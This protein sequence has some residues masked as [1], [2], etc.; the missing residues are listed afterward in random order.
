MSHHVQRKVLFPLCSSDDCSL[1]ALQILPFPIMKLQVLV[2]L[3]S[4]F[5]VLSW[6]QAEF[7]TSIGMWQRKSS[8]P[9][10]PSAKCKAE[11]PEAHSEF[12]DWFWPV[13]GEW[14]LQSFSSLLPPRDPDEH[15]SWE[16]AF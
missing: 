10:Q 2:M 11:L 4:W 8:L 15:I 13:Q 5:G 9:K 1:D 7:F 16:A 6:V 14:P 3:M 12:S